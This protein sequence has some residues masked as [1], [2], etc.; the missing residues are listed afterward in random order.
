MN[1]FKQIE[2]LLYIIVIILVIL[3]ANKA[4]SQAGGNAID[5][6]NDNYLEH[7]DFIDI[8]SPNYGLTNKLTV[9]A[10]IKWNVNPQTYMNN[11]NEQEGKN[12]DIVTMDR[13]NVKDNGQFWLQHSN[14]NSRFQWAIQ[15]NSSRRT[16][17]SSTTPVQNTWYY[18]VGVYDGSDPSNTMKIYVNGVLENSDNPISGNINSYNS[19]FRL[20]IGRLPSGYRLFAGMLDEIRIYKRALTQQEIREQMFSSSTVD[21]ASLLSYWSFNQSSGSNIIDAGSMHMNGTFYTSLVDVHDT[22][23]IGQYVIYDSDKNWPINGWA[24]KQIITVAGD[25]VGETNI[26]TSND[27]ISLVLQNPW[28]TKPRL[29]DL[30]AGTGMTWY[31]IIDPDE[32]VQWV[33]STA[34]IGSYVSFIDTKTT[35][36][37]GISGALITTTITSTPGSSNNLVIYVYGAASGPPVTNGESFPVGVDRRSNI[38]WGTYEW[39][40]VTSNILIDFSGVGGIL[41]SSSIKLLRR[42]RFSNSWA[43]VSSAVLDQY[44]MTFTLFGNTSYYEYSLGGNSG[45]P[46]P[47]KLAEFN[48]AVKE[49]IVSLFWKTYSEINNKGFDIERYGLKSNGIDEWNKI[50]FTEGMGT[51]NEEHYYSFSDKGL[52]KGTYSYRLKQID[53]NGNFE[54]YYLS[55][56]VTINSP[57]KPE[58]FQ[59][60]PNPSNPV[61]KIDFRLSVNS[62]VSLIVYDL[63]GRQV[64]E[65]I[66]KDM[67]CGYHSVQFD[68]SNLASGIYFYRFTAKSE[69]YNYSSVKRMVLIK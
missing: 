13:H 8:G 36:N 52:D 34:S 67:E 28:V 51:A 29:D 17:T 61:S 12:A 40:S 2:P 10:W 16:L 4:L 31:G 56:P 63:T 66:N 68:G 62:Y 41:N 26:V 38:V 47:V 65:L 21:T 35:T 49:N 43:E 60:Y 1:K 30:G 59:N 27:D 42:S 69:S 48:S 14:S 3:A 18:V 6:Y 50:S 45:N 44:N 33:S 55:T 11:H 46:L 23:S 25:G 54:Y 9:C 32:T 5:L 15:N 7:G 39:G 58:I 22:T 19:L 53:Y 64:N 57:P 20:N 37:T 24:N